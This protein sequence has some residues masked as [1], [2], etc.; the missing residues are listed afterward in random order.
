MN[1][2]SQIEKISSFQ[3]LGITVQP[4][5][6]VSFISEC[7]NLMDFRQSLQNINLQRKKAP[8]Y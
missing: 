5:C 4:N 8:T 7:T 3:D 6:E 2:E 1:L